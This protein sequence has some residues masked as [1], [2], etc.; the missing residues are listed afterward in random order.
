MI[1]AFPIDGMHQVF[2][3]VM[4]NL[5]F[6]WVKGKKTVKKSLKGANLEAV[7]SAMAA[8]RSSIPSVFARKPRSLKELG[9]WKGTGLLERYRVPTVS[10][11]HRTNRFKKLS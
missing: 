2:E 9:Y 7:N 3:G 1:S 11:L 5:L 4:K 8:F 6:L 10:S